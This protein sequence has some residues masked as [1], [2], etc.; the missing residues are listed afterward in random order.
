MNKKVLGLSA[1]TILLL[2][3]VAAP[4][5]T[6]A[7]TTVFVPTMAKKAKKVKVKK[8]A[9]K[10]TPKAM[11][12]GA[13]HAVKVTF[14]PSKPTNKKFT[15]SSSNKK[16]IKVS[17]TKIKAL[18][19]GKA[20]ITVKSKDGGKTH[21]VTVTVKKK[22]VAVKSIKQSKTPS[23]MYVGAKHAVKVTFNPSKPTSKSYTVKSSNSKVL[24]VSGKTI[25]AL[26]AGKATVTV[27]SGNGKTHK[28]TVAVKTKPVAVTSIKHSKTP[29]SM[30]V[31][32]THTV[33]A[34][35]APSNATDP[36]FTVSTS[37]SKVV[38]VTGKKLTAK[39][40]GTVTITVKSS[41]GKT[42]TAKVT[43]KAKKVQLPNLNIKS[44]VVEWNGKDHLKD[45]LIPGLTLGK[46]YSLKIT[47]HE[48]YGIDEKVV[49]KVIEVGNYNFE[50]TAISEKY[51]GTV[52]GSLH[53]SPA[54]LPQAA[55][56]DKTTY[57]YTGE[58]IKPVVTFPG[59]VEGRD[60]KVTYV[61]NV[62]VG[63]AYLNVE[64]IGNYEGNQQIGFTIKTKPVDMSPFT[65][66]KTVAFYN[67]KDDTESFA[68]YEYYKGDN[69]GYYSVEEYAHNHTKKVTVWQDQSGNL[70]NVNEG[71]LVNNDL[72]RVTKLYPSVYMEDVAKKFTTVEFYEADDA[73][74]PA[75]VDQYETI[76]KDGF[77]LGYSDVFIPKWK[78]TDGDTRIDYYVDKKTGK[79]Y[80]N[81][82]YDDELGMVYPEGSEMLNIYADSPDV[83]KLYAVYTP[84]QPNRVTKIEF[85]EHGTETP[86][87]VQE[88][89]TINKYG[90]VVEQYQPLY[91][92]GMT[93]DWYT[94]DYWKDEKGNKYGDGYQD[95]WI[96]KD[97]DELIKLY[98]VIREPRYVT[99]EL[100]D[101]DGNLYSSEKVQTIS[102]TGD[103]L[104]VGGVLPYYIGEDNDI[105][106]SFWRDEQ[107]KLWNPWSDGGDD[108]FELNNSY[109]DKIKFYA[110]I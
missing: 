58:E 89:E 27:T 88:I 56:I 31:G 35:I 60:Y 19:A 1:A 96:S 78:M 87:D 44:N 93:T 109:S 43:V 59:Y 106:V 76:D 32:G 75:Y 7:N 62:K 46:D 72:E 30:T 98:A 55:T 77:S 22:P 21:K 33:K 82:D 17:G 108:Y 101:E 70:Y 94:I 105:R 41:N 39:A 37:N 63:D 91:L 99:V 74:E 92:P 40:P 90:E 68:S 49:D 9:Q 13:S 65:E 29:T 69:P 20:V 66:D 86:S 81:G 79:K 104:F 34:S 8:I 26:K 52:Y 48:I 84:T 11:Y 110:V 80:S 54:D 97:S 2:S 50:A 3:G 57:Y 95:L 47:Y 61:N 5:E 14:N 25:K 51:K 71:M 36:S 85:Y 73:T 18:K 53:V 102:D 15:V 6:S 23:S 107:G 64:G 12:V 16:V 10:K 42:H 28:V 83:I 103:E 67:S 38:T 100:Y 45:V 24:K 4:Q